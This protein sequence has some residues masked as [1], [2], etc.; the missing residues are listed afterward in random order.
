MRLDNAVA[1]KFSLSRNK[2]QQMIEL[3]KVMLDGRIC[4]KPAAEVKEN[5]DISLIEPPSYASIGGE[6]LAKALSDFNFSV[7]DNICLDIGASNGGFTD[8]LLQ[9]GAKQVI[10]VDIGEC[11]FDDRLKKDPRVIIKDKTNARYLTASDVPQTCD[12]ACVDVSFISLKLILP[13]VAALIRQGGHI[14]ALVKPQFEVGRRHLSKSG[15]VVDVKARERVLVDISNYAV[16]L[17]LEVKGS[18]TAPIRE[19]KN[20]EY[21]LLLNKI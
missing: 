12:F 16:Q 10:A 20:V 9:N 2:A 1:V 4:N 21:L 8:C 19:R 3:S 5:S 18:C 13:A 11:A 15:I 14:I 6:K 7:R 17:G